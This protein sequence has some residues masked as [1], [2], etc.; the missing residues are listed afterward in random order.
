MAGAGP[1]KWLPLG[2][3][4]GGGD[5]Q[6]LSSSSFQLPGLVSEDQTRLLLRSARVMS[7]LSSR[8][9]HI[10]TVGFFRREAL[11]I[12]VAWLCA[13]LALCQ[14][15]IREQDKEGLIFL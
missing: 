7:S 3:K 14:R 5:T 12:S 9:A 1:G 4:V 11:A 6:P 2:S 10:K 15:R 13:S 8:A